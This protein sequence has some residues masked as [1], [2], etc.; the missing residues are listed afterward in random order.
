MLA[1]LGWIVVAS[2]LAL[3]SLAAWA[4]HG[5]AVWTVSNAG[6]LTGTASS[7]AGLQL[8]A[9]L[10]PWVPTELVHAITAML[11]GLGPV[12][13]GLL[14]AAPALAGGL[15][16]LAWVIWGIGAIVLVALGAAVH[17]VAAMWRRRVGGST[18]GPKA[19]GAP[20]F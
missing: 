2:M 17:V 16:V 6:V 12:I 10:G 15:T 9:W 13:D 18:P 20:A 1:V 4:T 5:V 3:W 11:V 14:Q 7:V 19:A 8:P